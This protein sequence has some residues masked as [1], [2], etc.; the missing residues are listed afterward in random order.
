MDVQILTGRMHQI[1]TQLAHLGHPIIGDEKY[2]DQN[3]NRYFA[4]HYGSKRLF[5]HASLI[6]FEIRDKKYEFDAPLAEEL[7]QIVKQLKT[8]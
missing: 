5:L 1:R 7:T 2:G 4:K 8:I 3:Q 6:S